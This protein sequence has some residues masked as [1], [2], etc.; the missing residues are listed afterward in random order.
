[1]WVHNPRLSSRVPVSFRETCAGALRMA[2]IMVLRS[3]TAARSRI[4]SI[5]PGPPITLYYPRHAGD[6]ENAA[7][8]IASIR[9]DRLPAALVPNG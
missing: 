7:L 9:G 8:W 4:P 6:G 2:L 3:A 1:M 5:L